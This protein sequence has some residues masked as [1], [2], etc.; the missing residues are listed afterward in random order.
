MISRYSHDDYASAMQALL[1]TGRVWPRHPDSTQSRVLAALAWTY[2]RSDASA[3]S[4][5]SGAFPPTALALLP[6][7]EAT[8]GLPDDC[9]I[10][11]VQT[12]QK[13]RNAVVAKLIGQGNL[14]KDYYIQVAKALG[15]DI[16]IT[17]FRQSRCGFSVCGEALNGEDWPWTWRINAGETTY[18]QA[19]CGQTYCG[20][21]LSTW[22]NKVL[23]CTLARIAPPFTILLFSYS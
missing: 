21:P 17:E 6:E 16:T 12:I 8:M 15:Y 2:Q 19:S 14:S 9:S 13:R 10:G 20:E 7:W 23:E 18:V 4:L 5:L 11:E 3:L 1:P 22:G